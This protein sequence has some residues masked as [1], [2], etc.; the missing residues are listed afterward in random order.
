MTTAFRVN[1]RKN[2]QHHSWTREKFNNYFLPLCYFIFKNYNQFLMNQQWEN[3]KTNCIID[4]ACFV[5]FLL[6][7]GYLI[8]FNKLKIR[9]YFLGLPKNL[10][11]YEL[12]NIGLSE[13]ARVKTRTYPKSCLQTIIEKMYLRVLNRQ[14]LHLVIQ[15]ILCTW[16]NPWIPQ[17]LDEMS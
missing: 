11:N 15:C 7:Y 10:K 4:I 3:F 12:S 5:F 2:F 1:K 8:K 14:D 16:G 6:I 17:K 13:N 9:K